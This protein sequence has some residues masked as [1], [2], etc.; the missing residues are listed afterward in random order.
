MYLLFT[1]FLTIRSSEVELKQA[2]HSIEEDE[3]HLE[4]EKDV[5]FIYYVNNDVQRDYMYNYHIFN[6]NRFL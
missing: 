1:L 5:E 4:R 2:S 6:T 3:D